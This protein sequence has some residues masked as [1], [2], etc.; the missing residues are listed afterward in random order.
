MNIRR[1]GKRCSFWGYVENI[2]V[3]PRLE[4]IMIVEIGKVSSLQSVPQKKLLL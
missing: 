1:E 4:I 2:T 3:N